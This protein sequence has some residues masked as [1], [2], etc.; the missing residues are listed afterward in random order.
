[1]IQ[2]YVIG[3]DISKSK[4][5][6]AVLS[7]EIEVKIEK[8]V[9]NTDS[10]IHKFITD[11]LSDLKIKA[12]DLLICCE[13]TGIY[14]RPLERVCVEIGVGLW[15]EHAVKIKRA[16]IDMRGKTPLRWICNPAE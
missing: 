8:E 12:S 15:V 1:M 16:S 5:D 10:K 13:N 4:I 2:K 9:S 14:N 7:P 11:V 6:C 3:I